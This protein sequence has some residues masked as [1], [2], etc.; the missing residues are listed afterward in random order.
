MERE[1]VL[2]WLYRHPQEVHDSP[3]AVLERCEE[4]IHARVTAEAW[5]RARDVARERERYWRDDGGGAHA[6]E[7]F[8]ARE[9]C[10][11]LAGEMRR[12]EP[13]PD[14]GT[15]GESVRDATLEPLGAAGR[16]L[17]LR[18]AL[19]LARRE[20]HETWLE[21]MDYT[22]RRGLDLA[23]EQTF[24]KQLDFERTHG[25]AETAARVMQ[26]LAEDFARQARP[27]AR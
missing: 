13:V 26:I 7:A 4:S 8:V 17:L 1:E 14:A 10:S 22:R 18:Y 12:L 11:E 16:S 23:H 27:A 20:E 6:S 15:V 3:E 5:R 25:Y 24:S 19:D 2:D 21:V 9:V